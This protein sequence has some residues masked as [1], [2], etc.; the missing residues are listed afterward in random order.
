MRA[1]SICRTPISIPGGPTQAGDYALA[2]ETHAEWLETLVKDGFATAAPPVRGALEAFYGQCARIAARVR[3]RF[4]VVYFGLYSFATQIAGGLFIL[5]GMA[6]PALG[7]RWPLRPITEWCAAHV[8]G[9]A[10]PLVY[11]GNSADTIFHWVQMAWL[12]AAS[13]LIATVWWWLDRG[14]HDGLRVWSRLVLR[15][16]L[17]AQMFYYGMAKVI[18]S[19]FPPPS[20]VTLIEPVGA[21]SLSDL[22]WTFVGAS[23]PYQIATGC[24][25]LLA[26][27]LLLVPV[28]ATA[29]AALAFADMLQVLL[30]NLA[31]DFG[32]K[33]ISAHLLVM[34]AILLAPDARRVCAV[35]AGRAVNAAAPAP[36][37]RSARANRAALVAQV[38]V[39]VYLMAVFAALSGRFWYAEG[40]GRA[41]KSALYGI[42]NVEELAVDGE[43]R[44][45]VLNEYDRRW[46]RV[47]FDAPQVVVFQRT[48]DSLAH[49]GA[50]HDAGR[51]TLALT[52]GAATT[53]RATFQVQRPARDRLLLEGEMDGHRIRMRLALVELD[54]FRLLNISLGCREDA[55]RALD[56]SGWRDRELIHPSERYPH[57]PRR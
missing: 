21:S 11:A 54:T 25:E 26:G 18:P 43:V 52:K 14:R 36:L 47:I 15:F 50:A 3:F 10:G 46:R 27:V 31:Y 44:P 20:L 35:L 12:F 8:F 1:V 13:L 5:P 4:G 45:A 42:W 56:R 32:L 24:A 51:G 23:L 41:P 16:A 29:G 28:T 53:W 48:D 37:F 22:L 49:Y 9:V 7:T 34:A 38:A 57:P 6:L 40:G 33:Q 17:A 55:P 2:D 30:L 19:Q 39:G